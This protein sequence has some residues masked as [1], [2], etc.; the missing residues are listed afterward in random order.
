MGAASGVAT[1]V[2]PRE[3]G[4]FSYLLGPGFCVCE[5][6]H[7][8]PIGAAVHH[9]CVVP[10]TKRPRCIAPLL[11]APFPLRSAKLSRNRNASTSNS[12]ILIACGPKARLAWNGRAA[13]A[14]LLYRAKV[15]LLLL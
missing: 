6:P 14:A 4:K 13:G 7:L 12:A 5:T 11:S 9:T 1:A 10:L 2:G 8:F 15:H 3:E